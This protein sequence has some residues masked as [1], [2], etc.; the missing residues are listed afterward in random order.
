MCTDAEGYEAMN[1]QSSRRNCWAPKPLSPAHFG[2]LIS[3]YLSFSTRWFMQNGRAPRGP[4]PVRQPPPI[5]T[6]YA[7]VGVNVL[8]GGP[9]SA[10]CSAR[11]YRAV[12]ALASR[13]GWT[14]GKPSTHLHTVLP[15]HPLTLLSA[16]KLAF[17]RASTSVS[18]HTWYRWP[19]PRPM[20]TRPAVSNR[21]LARAASAWERE[22]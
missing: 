19:S 18:R 22:Q 12:F 17:L 11:T 2:Y 13:T 7:G 10:P 6:R 15:T 3:R 16:L 9:T 14:H 8:C 20:K 5:T 21:P 1:D 4:C